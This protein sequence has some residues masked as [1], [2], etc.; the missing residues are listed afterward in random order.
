MTYESKS[1]PEEEVRPAAEALARL[2]LLPLTFPRVS[3]V[4]QK[5]NTEEK[6]SLEKHNSDN[7]SYLIILHSCLDDTHYARERK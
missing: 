1:S 2:K 5:I 6:I 4:T 7:G 3:F